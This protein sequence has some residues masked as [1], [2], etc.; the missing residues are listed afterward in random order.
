[1]RPLLLS[2]LA[3]TALLALAASA[4]GTRPLSAA[5]RRS[6]SLPWQSLFNYTIIAL[7][8]VGVVAFIAVARYIPLDTG[9]KGRSFPRRVLSTLAGVVGGVALA[10]LLLRLLHHVPKAV[11]PHAQGGGGKPAHGI[12][13]VHVTFPWDELLAV[14]GLGLLLA[15]VVFGLRPRRAGRGG[16]P[17]PRAETL[18]EAISDSLDDLR[19]DPDLRRAIEAAYA[20]MERALAATGVPRDPSEAPEEYLERALL[21]GHTSPEAA[22]RLTELFERAKFSQHEPDP[23]MRD[24]AIDA[25]VAIRDELWASREV[26]A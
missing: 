6:G 16:G 15:L 9:G 5:G 2:A 19:T 13:S 23:R 21:S 22:R 12:G 10:V 24:D 1:M 11:H 20:R 14:L 18:E 25:L 3:V 17:G 26:A 4:A 7:V 8:G